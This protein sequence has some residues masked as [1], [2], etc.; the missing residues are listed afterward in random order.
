MSSQQRYISICA[1][2]FEVWR[3]A[4]WTKFRKTPRIW[5]V[6]RRFFSQPSAKRNM[7]VIKAIHK[8]LRQLVT[9]SGDAMLVSLEERPHS[10]GRRCHVCHFD[11]RWRSSRCIRCPTRQPRPQFSG[12][13][14]E[15][16]PFFAQHE[17]VRQARGDLAFKQTSPLHCCHG[18]VTDL[19]RWG[20]FEEI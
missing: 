17:F 18:H 4:A 8:E 11:Q 14:E 10:A 20:G 19:K 6:R 3:L 1:W 9:R 15:V 16:L 7:F 5:S 13:G 2:I 12:S